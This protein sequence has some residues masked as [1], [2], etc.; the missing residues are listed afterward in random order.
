[1]YWFGLGTF[2]FAAGASVADSYLG[3][4]LIAAHLGAQGWFMQ[5]RLRATRP[6]PKI[7]AKAKA[8]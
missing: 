6:V 1:M 5:G 4:A 8:E 7:P 2:A 3:S